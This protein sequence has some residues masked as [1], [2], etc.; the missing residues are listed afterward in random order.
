MSFYSL[1]TKFSL[2]NLIFV[3]LIS[4]GIIIFN[5]TSLLA[6]ISNNFI[7][8]DDGRV[9]GITSLMS[10]VSSNDLQGI[11]FFSKGGASIVNQ[12]NMG[13]ATALHIACREGNIDAV[14]ALIE[15]GANPNIADNEG[16]TPLM[17]AVLTA[18]AEITDLLIDKG[19]DVSALNSDGDSVIVQAAASD[20]AKCLNIIFEKGNIVKN[21]DIKILQNQINTAYLMAVNR[22]NKEISDSLFAY[23]DNV[24][25]MANLLEPKQQDLAQATKTESSQTQ[26]NSDFTSFDIKNSNSTTSKKFKLIVPNNNSEKPSLIE[27]NNI[28]IVKEDD[29][30]IVGQKDIA[31]VAVQPFAQSSTALVKKFKFVKSYDKTNDSSS[32]LSNITAKPTEQGSNSN[33]QP[34][35][36]TKPSTLDYIA[37]NPSTTSQSPSNQASTTNISVDNSVNTTSDNS[38]NSQK[39]VYILKSPK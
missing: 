11:A 13:G 15:N 34:K 36:S 2:R 16:W 39:R 19:A 31:P 25:K 29:L 12:Q 20:C 21:M 17:R 22:E 33:N 26:Q 14:K 9:A 38:N 37:Q 5:K 30:N 32:N 6:E 1:S 35:K 8:T 18:N 24:I 28:S 23:Q 3:T 7:K 10:A 27:S 4:T